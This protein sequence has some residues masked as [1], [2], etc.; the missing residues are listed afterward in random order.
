MAAQFI[1]RLIKPFQKIVVAIGIIVL[2]FGGYN[3]LLATQE[4][5]KPQ[6]RQETVRQVSFATVKLEDARPFYTAFGTVSASRT[7]D[8]RFAIAGEVENVSDTFRNGVFVRK[9]DDLARLDTELLVI[10]RDEISEQIDAEERNIAALETQL[11]LRQ[12]QFERVSEMKAA[13]VASDS[14]LDDATLA[15]SVAQ[16]NLDQAKSRLRQFRLSLQRAERNLRESILTVPFDG[17]L[18]G[19]AVGEGRVI[20]SANALGVLTDLSSLEVSFVVPAEVYAEGSTLIDDTV[21]VTWKAGGRDVETVT[22]RITRAEGGVN[23]AEGGGRLYAAMPTPDADGSTPIPDGAF[24][25]VR[26]PTLLIEDVAIIP[27]VALFERDT[28]YVIKNGRAEPRK[29]EVLSRSDGFLFLKGDLANGD[30]VIVTRL[31]GLGTGVR[32]EGVQ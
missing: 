31:P 32:V 19:V 25:E 20:S 11:E 18:S 6:P 15:L 13:A 29:V 7:A 3:I 30:Q 12:R 26:L 22:A 8:L 5:I 24:V 9:G 27:D 1:R 17:V 2:G 10:A 23:A 28:V 16:N 4:E 14:R 21:T